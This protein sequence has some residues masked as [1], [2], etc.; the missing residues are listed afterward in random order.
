MTDYRRAIPY[1]VL[2]LG[3]LVMQTM[4]PAQTT[5]AASKQ[6]TGS[7]VPF[8]GC[9]SD[10]QV[11]PLDAPKGKSKVLSIATKKAQRLAYYKAKEGQGVLAPRGWYCFGTYGSSGASLFVSPQKIGADTLLSTTWDLLGL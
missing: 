8:V 1:G 6:A 10:G 11:G 3:V 9:Q 2:V 7:V 4:L 5:N